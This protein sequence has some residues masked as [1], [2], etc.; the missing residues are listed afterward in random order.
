MRIN[1]EQWLCIVGSTN[2]H[3]QYTLATFTLDPRTNT[4]VYK[5]IWASGRLITWKACPLCFSH[6][7]NVVNFA[8]LRVQGCELTI[9]FRVLTLHGPFSHTVPLASTTERFA[10]TFSF[11]FLTSPPYISPVLVAPPASLYSCVSFAHPVPRLSQATLVKM[12]LTS[13]FGWNKLLRI[14]NGAVS[15]FFLSRFRNAGLRF[16][17][18]RYYFL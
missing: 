9:P 10:S 18:A 3:I 13:V 2:I 8:A 6:C 12:V 11:T 14:C 4:I 16:R 15:V 17:L 7:T 5:L 1:Y